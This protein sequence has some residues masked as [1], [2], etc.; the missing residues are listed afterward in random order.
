MET[1]TLLTTTWNV[2][3]ANEMAEGREVDT[4]DPKHVEHML[5]RTTENGDGSHTTN[6]GITVNW[7]HVPN[8]DLSKPVI[9]VE[10]QYKDGTQ[11]HM[12]IDGWHR[13]AK[14]LDE[15]VDQLPCVVLSVKE[16]KSLEL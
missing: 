9:F 5:Q 10:R 1:F 12:M 7:D 4:F 3:K 15:G 8:V 14:A 13:V 16:G 6:M 2:D 11:G